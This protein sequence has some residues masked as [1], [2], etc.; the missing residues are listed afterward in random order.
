MTSLGVLTSRNFEV[1]QLF[2]VDF[3]ELLRLDDIDPALPQ[4]AFGHKCARFAK[5]PTG[6]TLEQASILSGL[7]EPNQ[8]L[9]IFPLVGRITPVHTITYSWLL[10]QSPNWGIIKSEFF[11][12]T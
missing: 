7:P 2:L 4:L 9:L 5:K 8:E 10:T 1:G 3:S 11:P 6:F 12:R